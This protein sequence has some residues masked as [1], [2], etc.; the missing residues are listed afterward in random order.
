[1]ELRISL[2]RL[3]IF[4]DGVNIN[5]RQFAQGDHT[6]L[7]QMMYRRV[8]GGQRIQVRVA[9]DAD[10]ARDANAEGFNSAGSNACG[11]SM[12]EAVDDGTPPQHAIVP[13]T[14][15]VSQQPAAPAD[16]PIGHRKEWAELEKV[17]LHGDLKKQAKAWLATN[18]ISSGALYH[19]SYKGDLAW[20]TQCTYCLSCDH[21][22]CFTQRTM[23]VGEP[24]ST[25]EEVFMVVEDQGACGGAPNIKALKIFYAHKYAVELSLT[26]DRDIQ[27]IKEDEVDERF[28]PSMQQ[29][30][31]QR[32]HVPGKRRKGRH[33]SNVCIGAFKH[34]L[35]NP[36][37]H[38]HVFTEYVVCTREEVRIP[39]TSK[40]MLRQ[41]A[42]CKLQC[43][44]MDYTFNTN[45]EGLLL[46]A[47]GPVGLNTPD[48]ALPSMRCIPQVFMLSH[49]EDRPSHTILLDILL[50]LREEPA[51]AYTDGFFDCRCFDSAMAHVGHSMYV[52]RCLQHCRTNL[53]SACADKDD[54]TG[55]PRL[56]DPV[57]K[58]S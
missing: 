41:A 47:A 16:K 17:T 12:G 55:Q 25:T 23:Q 2:G 49:S 44:V 11:S 43:C 32:K 42:T 48:D 24:G 6:A 35:A 28:W 9:E 21:S 54:E 51:T 29:L 56:K 19:S 3:L 34:F 7:V 52:H 58:N 8:A 53:R 13:W 5:L 46:G 45:V 15:P 36:P 18:H 14:A 33:F 57:M 50:K 40:L 38:V 30:K 10:D 26:P 31:D 1:M 20:V 4:P 39:F 37:Q 22:W 27:K